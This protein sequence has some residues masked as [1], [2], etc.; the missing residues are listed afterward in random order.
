MTRLPPSVLASVTLQDTILAVHILAAV[1]AFGVT[2]AYPIIF[3]AVSSHDT[4]ALP[5]LHRAGLALNRR[6]ITPGL[7]VVV[8]AG[9]YLASHEHMWKTFY[10][11]WGVG[12][13]LVFG[14]LAGGYLGPLERRL[15]ELSDRDVA[16]APADGQV[17]LSADYSAALTRLRVGGALASLLVV[18]TIFVMANHVG[19]SRTQSSGRAGARVTSAQAVN[20]RM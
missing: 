4:R 16:S 15:I 7:L 1:V 18:V 20:A 3:A 8:L 6:L 2:F 14:G 9:V 13:A 11:Q 19:G 17:Q 10:V 5:S 12:A